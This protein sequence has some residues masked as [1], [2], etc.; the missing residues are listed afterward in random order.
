MENSL[1]RVPMERNI[2]FAQQVNQESIVEITKKIISINDDDDF[3]IK[4]AD[5]LGF[6]YKPKPI[7]MYIDSYGGSIYQ[8]LGLISIMENSKIPIHTICTGAA[9]SC[10]FMILISGHKRFAYNYST[11]LYHQASS[12]TG[13]T[14][15]EIEDDV[16]ETKRLQKIIEKITLEKTKISKEKL[17]EVYEKKIDWFLTAEEALKLKVIDEI[18]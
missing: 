17:K 13:G 11:P 8:C 16:K 5:F 2:F 1:L 7:K 14:L 10:G 15:K 9:M 18:I 6:H 3:L 4:Q 12:A